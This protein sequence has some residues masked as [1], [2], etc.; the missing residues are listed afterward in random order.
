MI[1]LNKKI[2][3]LAACL[4]LSADYEQIWWLKLKESKLK[5]IRNS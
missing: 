5:T 1:S 4:S 2:N 3:Q